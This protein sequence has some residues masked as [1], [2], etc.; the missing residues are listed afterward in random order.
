M[1]KMK[2]TVDFIY[3]Y[4]YWLITITILIILVFV[5]LLF[6][7]G[8]SKSKIKKDNKASKKIIVGDS[9]TPF[10]AR[11]SSKVKML[12]DK[13]SESVL[14]KGGM[15]L[16]WLRDAVANY[17]TD[18]DVSHVVINIGTN[19]GFNSN[20][21][22]DGLF[23]NLKR[24]FP[25]AKFLVVKGSWGWGGNKGVTNEKVN[26]Y[27]NKFAKNGGIIVNPAIG[28]VADPHGNLPIYKEIG[29][30]IDALID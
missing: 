13:G 15:G 7:S 2:K 17:A 9:Q 22:V 27:Y 28:S 25:N 6:F 1:V 8:K 21:D 26:A 14:W 5:F 16:K 20:D 12:G 24:A 18:K 30:S 23:A 11:Q 10:I 4:K 19:G 29:K 3:K